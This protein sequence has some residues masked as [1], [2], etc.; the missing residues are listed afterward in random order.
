M[1]WVELPNV[2]GMGTFGDGGL[3]ASKP[4]VSAAA[5]INRMSN[6]CGT[7]RYDPS[8][9]TGADAC[10]FN[11]LYWTFLDDVRRR[12][13][14]VGRRMALVLGQLDR[15]PRSELAAMHAERSRFLDTLEPEGSGWDFRYDQ[16]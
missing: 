1:E 9:R 4:Y 8:L 6:Y 14:D 3:M 10:P 7:C 11:Y 12:G 16:G 2:V 13:L 5:Y 15:L